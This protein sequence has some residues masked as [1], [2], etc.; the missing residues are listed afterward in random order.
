MFEYLRISP[1]HGHPTEYHLPGPYL[2]RRE[3]G[4]EFF[5]RFINA[6]IATAK[7]MWIS[8]QN[9]GMQAV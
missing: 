9:L 1:P 3:I 8:D 5:L 4:I 6:D 7:M 2:D